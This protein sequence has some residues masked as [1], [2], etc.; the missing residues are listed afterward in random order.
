MKFIISKD[1]TIAINSAFVKT[2][3]I[4]ED[5][6]S[7][8]DNHTVI[9]VTAELN[10]A[11]SEDYPNCVVNLA[12]FDGGDL[13]EEYDAAKAYLSELVDKLNGGTK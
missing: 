10:K 7:Y 9:R 5:N 12:T 13:K 2:I 8:E 6:A 3:Y 4:E 1:S 11:S